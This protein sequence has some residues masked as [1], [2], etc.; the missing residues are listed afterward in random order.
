MLRKTAKS[1][2]ALVMAFL[3]LCGCSHNRD[4]S[5]NTQQNIAE[6]YFGTESVSDKESS[7]SMNT[8]L[9][10]SASAEESG[11]ESSDSS[12]HSSEETGNVFI[13]VCGAVKDPGVYVLPEGSR[14]YEAIRMAGGMTPEANEAF[15]NQA[16]VLVDGEQITVFTKEET[17]GLDP[18]T[19]EYDIPAADQVSQGKININ[20]ASAEELTSLS[21]IGEAKALAIIE[22][23]ETN[24]AFRE[25]SDIMKVSGIGE[26]LYNKIKDDIDVS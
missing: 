11:K 16:R 6:E 25:T 26:A 19:F 12:D 8:G 21:G 23:R 14:V 10:G 4:E 1:M 18:D 2:A 15:V 22:Y 3:F 20:K 13:Y 17:Q 5:V 9:S 24:G 7:D